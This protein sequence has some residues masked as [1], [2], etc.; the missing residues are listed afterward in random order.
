RSLWARSHGPDHTGPITRGRSRRA[1]AG[2]DHTRSITRCRRHRAEPVV[3]ISAS[4]DLSGVHLT[5]PI[6]Q[7]SVAQSRSHREVEARLA[8]GGPGLPDPGEHALP[9]RGEP[10]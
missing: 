1:I 10:S 8:V 3:S 5:E 7:A 2:V 9:S 6:S 4:V